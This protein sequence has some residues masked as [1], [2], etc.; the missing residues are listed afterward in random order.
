MDYGLFIEPADKPSAL[1]MLNERLGSWDSINHRYRGY[2]RFWTRFRLLF[3]PWKT[4]LAPEGTPC[5]M[6]TQDRKPL[7]QYKE[8]YENIFYLSPVPKTK[9]TTR[10]LR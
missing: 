2:P 6:M 1:D 8:L 9:E 3:R 10:D 7:Y 4:V 5:H